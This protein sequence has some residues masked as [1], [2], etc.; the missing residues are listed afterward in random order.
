MDTLTAEQIAELRETFLLFDKDGDGTVNS[1]ELGTVM[2]QLGQEP[3]EEELRQ[4]IAEVD[5]DGSGEIEFEEFC[6]MMAN[7][8]NQPIDS[9]QELI[10]AFEIFDDE[11]RGYITMEEFR[12]VM[13]TLGE[14]L[15]HS[16]VDE[17]MTMTGIGKNG[18]VK[19]KGM[20]WF[21]K[22]RLRSH[23]S[24]CC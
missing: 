9:P 21:N 3:S 20:F 8:M 7:R 11:K 5:E 15:S 24:F 4:M 6:T 23:I 14:K 2:R 1:D 18:K 10:E 13:T 16:D 12:S 19:Y 22:Q 17:M